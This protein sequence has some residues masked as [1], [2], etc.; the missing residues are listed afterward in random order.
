MD[1]R[2]GCA[3][4]GRGGSPAPPDGAGRP[5]PSPRRMD[6]HSGGHPPGA[7]VTTDEEQLCKPVFAFPRKFS[8]P[9]KPRGGTREAGSAALSPGGQL[10]AGSSPA[11]GV[12]AARTQGRAGRAAW[13]PGGRAAAPAAQLR[14]K[15]SSRAQAFPWLP[16]RGMG[17]KDWRARL[18]VPNQHGWRAWGGA[19]RHGGERSG[20]Q[21]SGPR[22]VGP[23]SVRVDGH[24]GSPWLRPF[25]RSRPPSSSAPGFFCVCPRLSP[26][27][28][29][30]RTRLG[31]V[32]TQGFA[33]AAERV[34]GRG[35]RAGLVRGGGGSQAGWGWGP[36]RTSCPL[37]PPPPPRLHRLEE[38]ER[39]PCAR[40]C[41]PRRLSVCP[42]RDPSACPASLR[43]EPSCATEADGAWVP[44]TC[45]KAVA[46]LKGEDSAELGPGLASPSPSVVLPVPCS[47]LRGDCSPG[48]GAGRTGPAGEPAPRFS[49]RTFFTPELP[50]GPRRR[51]QSPGQRRAV[52]CCSRAPPSA[53]V[54][55][56]QQDTHPRSLYN[57]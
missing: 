13:S 8:F 39:C 45:S 15:R 21:G 6:S 48:L 31:L 34:Q 38:D 35:Q 54:L 41:A 51:L 4:R 1:G 47:R 46:G 25:Q 11:P 32:A 36:V 10:E 17:S 3:R 2:A 18:L 37:P 52:F 30:G 23:R 16:V 20:A 42:W 12:C 29:A 5:A 43:S 14:R 19:R 40:P 27:P 49:G 44:P 22:S 28:T 56:V 7:S 24:R 55:N 50:G 53:Q 26:S 57:V 33:L 9:G